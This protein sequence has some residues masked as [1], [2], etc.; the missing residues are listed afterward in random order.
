MSD[1]AT[2]QIVVLAGTTG[3]GKTTTSKALV[4]EAEALWAHFGMDLAVSVMIAAKFV[5]GGP[6]CEEAIHL[7]ALDPDDVTSPTEFRVGP[8]GMTLMRA[9]H[10]MAA[11][12]ALAGQNVIMDHVPTTD[13]PLLQDCVAALKDLPVLFVALKPP[14]EVL[15]Q[16]IDDRLPIVIDIL[17]PEQGPVTNER[18]KYASDTI[19]GQIFTHD[20]FD[21]EIDTSAHT[22]A[23]VAR[24]ILKRVEDG[25]PGVAFRELA[26]RFGV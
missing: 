3:A 13:P 5:D 14:R 16:R 22:P 26:R 23:E 17:G 8:R 21:L 11:A 19:Y 7:Q 12:A 24:L 9:M 15:M 20:C 4:A 2:G 6:R 10:R 18:C 25:P 1:A